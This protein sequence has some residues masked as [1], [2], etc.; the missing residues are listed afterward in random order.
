MSMNSSA[1]LARPKQSRMQAAH[2]FRPVKQWHVLREND[3]LPVCVD[4]NGQSHWHPNPRPVCDNTR[5]EMSRVPLMLA[6]FLLSAWFGAATLFVIIGVREVRFVGFDSAMRDQLVLLRFP[7]YY[8]C[9][10]TLLGCAAQRRFVIV[11]PAEPVVMTVPENR[12]RPVREQ[13]APVAPQLADGLPI[14][15]NLQQR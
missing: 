4:T 15:C 2:R 1:L 10:F 3:R 5:V 12:R 6:R 11:S 8:A 7:A 9:G 14:R 13:I